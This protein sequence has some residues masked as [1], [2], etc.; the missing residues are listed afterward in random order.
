MSC[1][2][3]RLVLLAGLLPVP[4]TLPAADVDR[5][6]FD[7][8]LHYGA[9][10]ARAFPPDEILAILAR[11]RVVR[12]VVT[13][14]PPCHAE[15][16]YRR[17][18][19]RIVPILGVY[20]TAADKADWHRD[21]SLPARVERQLAAGPWRGVGELHLFAE[22]RRSPVFRRIVELA[23]AR[24]LPLLV[25]A[26]P[27]VIDALFEQV[28]EAT[29]IWAHAGAYPYPALVADYLRRHPNLHVDLSMREE[30]IAPAG[31]LDPDWMVLLM[32][33]PDR[34]LVGVDTY[35]TD[36]WRRF[37]QLTGQ[38]RGWLDQLPGEVA[39]RIARGNAQ[40]LFP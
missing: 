40:R 14:T 28:P 31:Q 8:H 22:Q 24:R 3:R 2:T 20:R 32:E 30:R 36:R 16:L 13:G 37:G 9:E 21:G 25:H 35:S 1:L 17:A 39:D 26:D 4:P 5:A 23:T 15:D 19:T 27:A 33:L 10:D 34:F 6:L 38:T 29:V 12:A 18:P 11:N 7:T